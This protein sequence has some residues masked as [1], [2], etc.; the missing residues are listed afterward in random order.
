M[1]N[2]FY[3][4]GLDQFANGNVDWVND[5]I[6]CVLVDSASYTPNTA[7]DANLDD[8]PGGAR[9]STQTLAGKSTSA[10]VLDASDI[11]FSSV[12]AGTYEYL[13][14]YKD[15]GVESTSTLLM[16]IDTATGLP[17]TASGNDIDVTWD[18][19]ANKIAKL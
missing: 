16:L 19:G 18:D 7:T 2:A 8:V 1:A 17:V 5:T 9:I 3:D 14:I 11:T 13:V 15:S 12:A 10:G 4:N 6:K